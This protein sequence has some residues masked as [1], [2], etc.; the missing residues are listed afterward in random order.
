ME[1]NYFKKKSEETL[2][3]KS[4]PGIQNGAHDRIH[5]AAVSLF[6]LGQTK[7]SDGDFVSFPQHNVIG[8]QISV[9][10]AFFLV[11]VSQSQNNLDENF[12][13]SVLRED[14]SFLL[15]RT[16]VFTQ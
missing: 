14:V 9:Y 5:L 2:W 4:S 1:N 16:E 6:L 10:D 7:I 13:D 15:K 11:E 8:C 3:K 12:P